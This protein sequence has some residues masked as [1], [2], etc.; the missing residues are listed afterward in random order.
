MTDPRDGLVK[1]VG[2]NVD[3]SKRKWSHFNPLVKEKTK[4]SYWE[5]KLIKLGLL[6]IFEVIDECRTNWAQMERHYIRFY[7]SCGAKLNNLAE[8]GEGAYGYKFTDEQK[9]TVSAGL[10]GV[11]KSDKHRKNSQAAVMI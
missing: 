4:N 10:K 6:P 5:R 9:A 7:K 1:Y 8:G 3:V 11:P 2:K